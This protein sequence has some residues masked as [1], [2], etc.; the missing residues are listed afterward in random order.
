[1]NAYAPGIERMMKRLF[2]SLRE[3]D[4]RRNAAIQASKLVIVR[5]IRCQFIFSGKN[6]RPTPDFLAWTDTGFPCLA[7]RDVL[8]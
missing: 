8:A 4:R 1:M 6:D 5:V 3:N 2:D 7:L